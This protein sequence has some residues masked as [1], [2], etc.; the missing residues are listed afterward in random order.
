MQAYKLLL[1]LLHGART[2]SA[3]G[4]YTH[5]LPTASRHVLSAVLCWPP[6]CCGDV[7]AAVCCCRGVLHSR[8]ISALETYVCECRTP[9]GV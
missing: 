7:L 6:W 8:K 2:V 1:L 9:V 4:W 5:R 3:V